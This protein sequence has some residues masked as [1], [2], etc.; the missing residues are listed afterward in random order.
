MPNENMIMVT[1]LYPSNH[2]HNLN[3]AKLIKTIGTR[4]K[5]NEP[6]HLIL[7]L[8]I[9]SRNEGPCKP[10]LMCRLTRALL[11]TY[12]KHIC[13]PELRQLAPL[14]RP[15]QLILAFANM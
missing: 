11:P 8:I 3:Q 15:G 6:A 13:I 7:V 14:R 5:S 9:V 10:V 2:F 4:I 12:T 1:K